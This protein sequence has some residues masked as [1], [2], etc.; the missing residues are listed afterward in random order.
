MVKQMLHQAISMALPPYLGIGNQIIDIQESAMH[1]I[2][3]HPKPRQTDRLTPFMQRNK[4][5][6]FPGLAPP[7]GKPIL[8]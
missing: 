8:R 2:L 7:S 1:Q 6:S 4:P 3:L 5:I